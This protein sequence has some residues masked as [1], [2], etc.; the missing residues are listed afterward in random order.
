MPSTG[1]S[2]CPS[3]A[4]GQP[5]AEQGTVVQGSRC[6]PITR[7]LAVALAAAEHAVGHERSIDCAVYRLLLRMEA[8]PRIGRRGAATAPARSARDVRGWRR[9]VGVLPSRSI[10]HVVTG[11]PTLA[12]RTARGSFDGCAPRKASGDSGAGTNQRHRSRRHGRI[13]RGMWRIL[14]RRH[15]IRFDRD[16]LTNPPPTPD[17]QPPLPRRGPARRASSRPSPHD[18]RRGSRQNA[19]CASR[20]VISAA[21]STRARS[22]SRTVE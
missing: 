13:R 3:I 18:Q 20:P 21:R 12:G 8:R 1:R 15:A 11:C 16:R 14:G 2:R 5:F 9:L 17:R 10:I 19:S 6:L 4:V 7:E 22:C